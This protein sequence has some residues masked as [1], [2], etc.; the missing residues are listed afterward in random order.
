MK[1]GT[2]AV[3]Y[4]DPGQWSAVFGMAFRDLCLHDIT[5]EQRLFKAGGSEL[6]H[7]T[8]SGGIVA[9]R[10]EVARSFL[11]ETECEWL[12]FVDSDMGFANDTVDRLVDSADEHKRPVMGGLCFAQKKAGEFGEFRAPRYVITPTIYQWVETADE[13]GVVPIADYE[14]DAVQ[15]ASATGAACLLIHRRVLRKMRAR[16]GDVW[17]DPITHPGVGE[18]PKPRTFSEDISFCL[19]LGFID[20]PLHVNTSVRTTHD[21]GGV[22][23]DE[24]TFDK[25]RALAR[26]EAEMRDGAHV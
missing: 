7:L 3:G 9:A 8:G 18:N 1:R 12:W 15:R 11:D 5:H 14:R 23:L 10:N 17:F 19:R 16:F 13:V 25:D 22:Y 6:R 21:K 2:V 4:L 20:E 26:L 24:E